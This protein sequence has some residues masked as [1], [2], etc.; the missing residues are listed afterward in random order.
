MFSF[1]TSIYVPK[2]VDWTSMIKVVYAEKQVADS[3]S[4]TSPSAAKPKYLAELLH[5]D[6]STKDRVSLV[7]PEAVS[8][9]D[10]KRCHE[11]IFV[12][13]VMSLK[14]PNGFGTFK[15]SVVDS[16]PYTNGAMYTAAKLA[17][18][19]KNPAV[20]L[21]SGF[22]HAG[23]YG[24]ER[25]GYFC[26]FNGLMI[27]ATKLVEDDG[28]KRVAIIDC[29][30]HYGNGTD[31]ILN[32]LDPERKKY[33]NMT[34]GALFTNPTQA[35]EYLDYFDVVRSTL[36]YFKPDVIL[37]QSGADVHVND[38]FGGVLTEEQML[39]RDIRMFTIAKDLNIPIAWDLAGG[40]Q[41]EP[42]GSCDYVLKLHMN[43]FLACQKVY[44]V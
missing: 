6:A 4:K 33:I 22:H 3:G 42:N 16:L 27:T 5:T 18:Q 37:Y 1:G 12:D 43:T 38:P 24:F 35:K 23:Y 2:L 32:V 14:R 21:V 25:F 29:D 26:T 39:E 11:A 40:Y 34:F 17:I 28:F 41:V 8:I 31:D 44:G 7:E 10:I 19:D 13:E 36:E 9:A 30:M 20:A 15:Q